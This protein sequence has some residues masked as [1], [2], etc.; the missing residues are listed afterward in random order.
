M[1]KLVTCFFAAVCM[2]FSVNKAQALSRL[3]SRTN[4]KFDGTTFVPV[5]STVYSYS[6]PHGGDPLHS[7]D[8]DTATTWVFNSTWE[9]YKRTYKAYYGPYINGIRQVTSAGTQL[10][11]AS[12]SSWKDS[13]AYQVVYTGSLISAVRVENWNASASQW[14]SVS[15]D[16]FQYNS[17]G[18]LKS[19]VNYFWV[20]SYWFNLYKRDFS[21]DSSATHAAHFDGDYFQ[22]TFFAANDF[23]S[24]C[25]FPLDFSS[26]LNTPLLWI[27][28]SVPK[29]RFEYTVDG[30][31]NLT[32]KLY[33]VWNDT[34]NA[35]DQK[36]LHTY[37]SF[38]ATNA[39]QVDD[40]TIYDT[41]SG[42]FWFPG[43]RYTQAYNSFNQLTFRQ[44]Q[45]WGA[46]TFAVGDPLSRY[47]YVNY[48]ISGV[49]QPAK[50]CDIQSYPNPAT[51]SIDLD[52]QWGLPEAFSISILDATGRM[53]YS[54]NVAAVS[55][56][57]GSIPVAQ[58]ST[59]NYLLKVTSTAGQVIK[60]VTITH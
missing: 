13:A 27:V 21:Y 11:D 6:N 44:G 57:H 16:V 14:D 28:G 9:K 37:S 26:C 24:I 25:F 54:S 34:T 2:L 43:M 33:S 7:M 18:R 3:L 36:T 12:T 41:S 35:W 32:Q 1:K 23:N 47:Y 20:G 38:V 60:E 53:V 46:S 48:T 30:T 52:I 59:G 55:H 49:E 31:D 15:K 4:L 39:P 5:D 40:I 42:G 56:Y 50:L 29:A 51:A 19:Q 58:F 10:W 8:Y 45:T 17:V 22:G